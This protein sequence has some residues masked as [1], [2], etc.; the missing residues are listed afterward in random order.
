MYICLIHKYVTKTAVRAM[1][2]KYKFLNQQLVGSHSNLE[3]TKE[4]S[5]KGSKNSISDSQTLCVH[6]LVPYVLCQKLIMAEWP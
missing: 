3:V 4:E 1:K 6:T 5:P 2:E